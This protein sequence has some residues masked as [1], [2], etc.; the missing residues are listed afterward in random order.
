MC[1]S[2][3]FYVS[4]SFQTLGMWSLLSIAYQQFEFISFFDFAAPSPPENVTAYPTTP[5][6]VEVCWKGPVKPN[7]ALEK[8]RYVV[9][10][11]TENDERSWASRRVDNKGYND[12]EIYHCG[13]VDNLEAEKTY[14]FKVRCYNVQIDCTCNFI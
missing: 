5:E 10:W 8:L 13:Y 2:S 1:G 4:V 7:G 6:Q 9:E 12:S 14:H 3:H 11:R